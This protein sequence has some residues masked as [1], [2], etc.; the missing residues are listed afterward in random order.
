[1]I[2]VFSVLVMMASACSSYQPKQRCGN[3]RAAKKKW[4]YYNSIQYR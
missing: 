3:S 4:N 1:M 2:L